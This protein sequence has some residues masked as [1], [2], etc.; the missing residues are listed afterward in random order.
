MKAIILKPILITLI[1]FAFAVSPV[2][3]QRVIK[4]TV[5]RE[6]KVAAGVTVE[7][8]K[9]SETFMTSFDGKYELTVPEKCKY[10][11][12]KF[13]DESK[14]LDISTNTSDVIDFSFDGVIP[15][16]SEE[17]DSKVSQ[18]SSSELVAAQDKDFLNN[19]SLYQQ[20]YKQKDFKSALVSW[21]KIYH[22]YPKAH[23]N[24]Y[25]HGIA[26]YQDLVEK[27][28][29]PKLKNA[30][31]DTLIQVY[32]KRIKNFD[33]KGFNLGHEGF[34]YLKHMINNDGSDN[35]NDTQKKAVLKKGY[36]YVS[37]SVKL[38]NDESEDVVLLLLMQT[39]TSLYKF[40]EFGK[41]KVIEC[42]DN[43]SK[44][45]NKHLAKDPKDESV[46][47]VR[48]LVDQLFQDSGAADCDA[49]ISIYESKFD[50]VSSNVEELKKMTQMLDRQ[51][52][53]GSPLYA[54]ASEKLY[55]LE[56]SAEAAY[57]MANLFVRSDNREKA[58]SYYKQAIELEKD[59]ANL[60]K[61][62]YLLAAVIWQSNPQ[63]A[64]TYLKKSIEN[65][66]SNGRAIMLLGD[67][68]AQNAKSYGKDDFEHLTVYW[69]AVD[70]YQKAK[71]ADP[72][73]EANANEK[74]STYS[75]NFPSKEDIF[76]NGLTVGQAYSVGSWIGE[77]TTV[78][79]RK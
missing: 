67:V 15:A 33:K 34:D 53:T 20:F 16:N 73:V 24:I 55:S 70:L 3:A 51:N 54:K 27:A 43:V 60:S 23:E 48:N 42:Y 65:N 56:P 46:I 52:C 17:N 13:I 68:Y 14:K 59:P 5:Y 28:A 2:L 72:A 30:Y 9:T 12:F 58:E 75:Q 40:G 39:T 47:K 66:S 74:I 63:Q 31:I 62:Y 22:F 38:Q 6:G 69:V 18:K 45:I 37:E 19:Y 77:S 50:A 36:N 7:A 21:R 79:E 8:Q 11:T 41:E 26:M 64:K 35:M 32:D 71:K 78:R 1:A 76:F 10:L 25:V 49:L 57:N 44:I 29:N 4:G 61:Y